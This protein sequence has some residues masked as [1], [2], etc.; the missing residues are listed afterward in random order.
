M[1][2]GRYQF[3]KLGCET[4]EKWTSGRAV[5][6]N[7]N[8]VR[9]PIPPPSPDTRQTREPPAGFTPVTYAGSRRSPIDDCV[10]LAA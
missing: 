3:G 10:V 8:L 7:L 6:L 2:P 9:L 5:G 4:L 1:L